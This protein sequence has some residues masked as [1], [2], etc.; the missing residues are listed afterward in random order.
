[1]KK[2]IRKEKITAIVP[3][4]NE[5]K[6][7]GKVLK[8]LLTSKK[9][10]EVIVVDDGSE[11]KT[12]NVAEHFGANVISLK[13]NVGKAKAMRKG[14]EN[15]DAEII[16]FF[17][18]DLIGLSDH[19]IN[20]LIDPVVRG[21]AVMSEGIRDRWW[22]LPA[23]IDKM[24]PVTFAISGERVIKKFV[25]MDIPQK[26]IHNM[27]DGVVMNYY[28]EVNKLPIAFV[29]LKGLDIV[30]KENKIGIARALIS[31]INMII[32]FIKIRI[33]I[34]LNK[35]DFKLNRVNK[36]IAGDKLKGN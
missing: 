9:L 27:T 5:E 2:L 21:Q 24:F 34:S 11:D 36:G 8:V 23:L 15:T 12:A 6:N 30:V 26:Y 18:A 31:R 16:A 19:H 3:A 10:D 25:F 13:K 32:E 17:D 14:V 22:G 1:M 28:C 20:C 4:F 33:M 29:L 7:I 35:K